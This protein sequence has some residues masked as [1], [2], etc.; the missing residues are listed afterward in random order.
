MT[1][2]P[3]WSNCRID[4]RPSPGFAWALRGL[5]ALAAAS[6]WLSALPP[7]LKSSM[8]LAALAGGA[9]LAQRYRR[10]PPGQLRFDAGKGRGE[11]NFACAGESCPVLVLRLRGP[12]ATLAARDLGG[13]V[14]WRHWWPDLLGA[15]QRRCLRIAAGVAMVPCAS[16]GL[17]AARSPDRT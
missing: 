9:W 12:M 17:A 1:S 14:F 10:L 8:A 2:S 7:T 3:A 16:R 5:G 15:E 6:A 13:R 4:W 11:W